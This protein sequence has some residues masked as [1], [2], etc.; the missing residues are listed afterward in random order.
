MVILKTQT[1]SSSQRFCRHVG[2]YFSWTSGYSNLTTTLW[3]KAMFQMFQKRRTHEPPRTSDLSLSPSPVRGRDYG[4]VKDT[5]WQNSA[6]QSGLGRTVLKVLQN[7]NR[8]IAVEKGADKKKTSSCNMPPFLIFLPFCRKNLSIPVFRWTATFFWRLTQKFDFQFANGENRPCH[9]IWKS[10]LKKGKLCV[11]KP[12]LGTKRLQ[13]PV[14][15]SCAPQCPA[16]SRHYEFEP[17]Q[18]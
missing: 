6:N 1:A 13:S 9:P 2:K 8:R 15:D 17:T 4:R 14:C 3:K 11:V 18:V 16:T 5:R 7:W 12:P 10:K